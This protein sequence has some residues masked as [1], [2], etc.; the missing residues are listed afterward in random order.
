MSGVVVWL[1]G[2]P[3]SGKSTFARAAAERLRATGIAVA[4]LDGDDVRAVLR[5]VPGYDDAARAEF[6][7]SL[8][9]LAALLAQQGLVVLVPATANRAVFRDHARLL[10]P[11]FV[12]VFVATPIEVCVRRDAKG[13]YARSAEGDIGAMPGAG[14]TYEPPLHP[15]LVLDGGE[16][17]LAKLVEACQRA[18][19]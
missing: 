5:P 8:S 9:G 6:Y 4:V 13:L 14:A 3:S 17:D 1:T 2:L 12:E 7:A 19:T 15:D 11:R 10:A 18:A 16:A